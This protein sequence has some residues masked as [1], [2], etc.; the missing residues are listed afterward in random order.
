VFDITDDE[1]LAVSLSLIGSGQPDDC[2]LACSQ[3]SGGCLKLQLLQGRHPTLVSINAA[4]I[5]VR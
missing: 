1:A 5:R 4:G 2:R 3:E